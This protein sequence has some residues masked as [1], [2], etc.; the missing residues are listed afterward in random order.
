[1]S[2]LDNSVVFIHVVYIVII[3]SLLGGFAFL[4]L[5]DKK[6]KNKPESES[7]ASDVSTS[8]SI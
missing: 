8:K 3:A 5:L 7:A 6:E 2:L 4:I 1:M